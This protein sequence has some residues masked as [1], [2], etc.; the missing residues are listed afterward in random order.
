MFASRQ[1]GEH[2]MDIPISFGMLM[3]LSRTFQEMPLRLLSRVDKVFTRRAL[4]QR[5]TK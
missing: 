3:L 2:A 1:Q 5:G 4:K